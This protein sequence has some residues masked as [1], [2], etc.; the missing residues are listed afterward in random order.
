MTRKTKLRLCLF[1]LMFFVFMGQFGIPVNAE[2]N[3]YYGI[4]VSPMTEKILL[5]PGDSYTGSFVAVNPARNSSDFAYKV[6][7]SP[8]FAT[9]DYNITYQK[10]GDYNQIVDWVT[11]GEQSGVLSPNETTEIKFRIDV[12]EDA[13]AGGQYVAI[14]V[15][16]DDKPGDTQKNLDGETGANLKQ[17]ISVAHTV[18]AEITGSTVHSGNISSISLPSFML[19]GNIVGSTAIENTGNVH[20]D[21]TYKLQI[22]PLF[23]NEEVYTNEENPET[24]I[25][26]PGRKLYHQTEWTETPSIGI[27]NAIYTVEFEGATEK[28]SRLI[29]ICPIW[30]MLIIL[31]VII[32]FV[33]WIFTR[34]KSK[35]SSKKAEN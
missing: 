12:P 28:I 18:F 8:F 7:V 20:G 9:E 34:T 10:N 16:A 27:F 35:K 11:V 6:Y 5:N 30:L 14:I 22:F 24:S 3:E 32:L 21:A 19:S 2:E 4:G 31:F 1:T 23:S 25:I 29:I 17:S 33:I 26:L 15:G 13:P